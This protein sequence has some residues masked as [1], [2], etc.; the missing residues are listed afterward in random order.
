MRSSACTGGTPISTE[1]LKYG[2]RVSVF[3][4]PAHPMLKTQ[5]ALAVVG[6]QAFG[7]TCRYEPVRPSARAAAAESDQDLDLPGP[8]LGSR[9]WS[10][11]G[12]GIWQQVLDVQPLCQAVDM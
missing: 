7:Y 6:P 12:S 10:S 4:L 1:G 2:L 8:G 5:E 3:A 9:I 11:K